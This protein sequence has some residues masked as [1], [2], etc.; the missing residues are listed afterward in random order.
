[1]NVRWLAAAGGRAMAGPAVLL[2][3]AL[4][5]L[6]LRMMSEPSAAAAMR[7]EAFFMAA[8]A[9]DVAAMRHAIEH[10]GLS[11]NQGESG[12]GMTP[13]M[14]AVGWRQRDAAEWLLAHGGVVNVSTRGYGWALAV[15]ANGRDGQ[16]LLTLLLDRGADPNV[17][18]RDGVTPLMQAAMSNNA[19]AVDTLLRAGARPDARCQYGNT[20]RSIAAYNGYERIVRLLDD[21]RGERASRARRTD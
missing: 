14:C 2:L 3:T 21:A 10:D 6:A 7:A 15:G 16:S 4:A 1:V 5:L 8:R 20:A 13:L 12:S 9:G 18:A 17:C 19:D 11:V